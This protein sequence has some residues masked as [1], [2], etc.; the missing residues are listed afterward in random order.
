[1]FLTAF[2]A[3]IH[4]VK[5]RKYFWEGRKDF[6]FPWLSSGPF[7]SSRIYFS[8]TEQRFPNG[9][10]GINSNVQDPKRVLMFN[11][12]LSRAAWDSS[13]NI[14]SLKKCFFVLLSVLIQI[15]SVITSIHSLLCRCEKTKYFKDFAQ[16]LYFIFYIF[17]QRPLSLL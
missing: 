11:S 12:K 4:L 5:K 10:T 2:T 15:I 17:L 13:K 8:T 9:F 16:T 1:M 7:I 6:L 14:L 3:W